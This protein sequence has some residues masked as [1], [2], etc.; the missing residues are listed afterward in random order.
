TAGDLTSSR[1]PE[2]SQLPE[3]ARLPGHVDG[4]NAVGFTADGRLL[5]TGDDAGTVRLWSLLDRDGGDG[6]SPTRP[7]LLTA[8]VDDADGDTS[9][10]NGLA[11]S[12]DAAW[13][14][15]ATG[16]G[17]SFGIPVDAA[18]LV[19]TACADPTNH[20]TTQ[21]WETHVPDWDYDP[22]CR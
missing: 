15:T 1:L 5:A 17:Q 10:I 6:G 12:P 20:V 7:V 4:V 16:T 19:A 3:V 8:V 21:E 22:P 14:A 13:L 2:I 11:F 9:W 18:T